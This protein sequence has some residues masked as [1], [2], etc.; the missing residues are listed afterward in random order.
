LIAG[1][2]V[3]PV[4]GD[5]RK[6]FPRTHVPHHDGA[7]TIVVLGNDAFEIVVRNG[8]IFDFHRKP[9]VGRIERWAFGH[10][11]RFQNT[12]EFETEI[13]V[14][15]RGAVH[16]YNEAVARLGFELARRLR[17]RIK[18]PLAFVFFQ[19][20]AVIVASVMSFDY[21]Y[22]PEARAWGKE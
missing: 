8:V 3:F 15:P 11:P 7:C 16:L 19:R 20:H 1:W 2:D 14:E 17:S 22:N 5:R 4:Y 9:L 6:R 10:G 21:A 18:A 12:I 13:V